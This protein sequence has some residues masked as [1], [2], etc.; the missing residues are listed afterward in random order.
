[1]YPNPVVASSMDDHRGPDWAAGVLG[2]SIPAEAHVEVSAQPPQ[3]APIDAVIRFDA[4]SESTT[5]G[6][7]RLEILPDQPLGSNVPTLVSGPSGWQ[8]VQAT[9]GG[10]AVEGPALPPGEDATVA[11]RAARLPDATQVVFKVLQSYANGQIDRWIGLP[12][13]D[14]VKP[15]SPAPI[16]I[17]GPAVAAPS[18][19]RREIGH[20]R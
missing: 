14:G 3:A 12:G 4:E 13:P 18:C 8:I 9:A 6:I 20:S 5:A 11:I 19:G 2:S 15:W 17:L 10:F 16:L 7:T 1:M